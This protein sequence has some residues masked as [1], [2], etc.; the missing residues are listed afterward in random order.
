VRATVAGMEANNQE[1]YQEL[2]H[3]GYRFPRQGDLLAAQG[4]RLRR[5][6]DNATLLMAHGYAA[7]LEQGLAMIRDAGYRIISAPIQS[8]VEAAHASGAVALLAHPGRRSEIRDYP[9]DLLREL[10]DEVPLDGLEVYYPTHSGTQVAEYEAMAG[11]RELL[12]SAGSDSHRPGQRLPVAYEA[13]RVAKLLA[14]L[15]IA[16]AE[17][18]G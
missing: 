16:L 3:R 13:A 6:V 2:R 14:R 4:G 15:G 17:E 9:T 10:L 5:P 8:V 11:E 12:V 7:D 18:S 1:V